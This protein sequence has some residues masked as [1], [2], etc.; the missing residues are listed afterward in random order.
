MEKKIVVNKS[1]NNNNLFSIHNQA[2][3]YN[4]KG[5]EFS[6][7]ND[8]ENAIICFFQALT[9]DKNYAHAYSNIGNILIQKREFEEAI[10]M[11][12]KAI[13]IDNQNSLYHFNL[14]IAYS[15]INNIKASAKEYKQSL[16]LDPRNLK[17]YKF[18]G[19]CYWICRCCGIQSFVYWFSNIGNITILCRYRNHSP[20]YYDFF[21][22]GDLHLFFVTWLHPRDLG[23]QF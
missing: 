11:Y 2:D 1:K 23:K 21:I 12:Q 20:F 19:N 7:K 16:K 8:F 14:G 10:N 5:L 18:L 6:Q 17:A 15:N 22:S 9:H 13:N 3:I 4:N